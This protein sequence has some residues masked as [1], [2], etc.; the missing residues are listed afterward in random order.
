MV[1][2]K[3]GWILAEAEFIHEREIFEKVQEKKKEIKKSK[4]KSKEELEEERINRLISGDP[5]KEEEQ[6]DVEF[7]IYPE[8]L[9]PVY[10]KVRFKKEDVESWQEAIDATHLVEVNFKFAEKVL[11]INCSI[12]EFDTVFF[13]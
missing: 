11:F 8:D 4:K 13:E 10:K 3:Q 1:T 2:S 9:T 5:E 7:A 12:E 6:E